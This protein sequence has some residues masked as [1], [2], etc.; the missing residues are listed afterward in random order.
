LPAARRKH[1][2]LA[3]LALAFGCAEAPPS[4]PN[5]VLIDVDCLRADHVSHLGYEHPTAAGLDAFREDAVLFTVARAPAS[6]SAASSASLLT[7]LPVSIHGASGPEPRLSDAPETL[8]EILRAAGFSTSALSHH[9]EISRPTGFAQGFDYFEGAAGP[10]EAHPDAGV[11]LDWLREWLATQPRQPFFLYLHPVNPH[12]PYRV[13]DGR[14]GALH[15]RPPAGGF[16]PGGEIEAAVMSGRR[17]ARKLVGPRVRRSLVE[18]YDTAVRYTLDRVGEMIEL[19]R[20]AGAYTDALVIVTGNHGEELFDHGGFGHGATL[21]EEVLRVPLYI[22]LPGEPRRHTV[23][24][25]VSLLD[26]VPSVV[27]LLG[28][29]PRTVAGHSLLPLMQAEPPADSERAF[30][31]ELREPQRRALARSLVRGRYKLIDTRRRYDQPSAGVELYDLVLDPGETDDIS[32][33]A[34]DVVSHLRAQLDGAE[35]GD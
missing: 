18:Q 11:M 17:P 24:T 30:V 23:E 1:P 7:G 32:E 3:S 13:P 20:H 8:A 31:A 28:L 9:F 33:R 14:S 6:A 5:V 10:I 26:V 12:S 22:K 29:A 15:G 27:D 19:L 21:Y 25:P 35:A 34:G 2:W 4:T 16:E